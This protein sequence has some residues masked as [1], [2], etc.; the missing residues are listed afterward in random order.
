VSAA[1]RPRV[2]CVDD[3]PNVVEG[4][5]LHLRKRYQ[6]ETAHSASEG[7][8]VIARVPDCAV[9][10]SDMRMPG[11]DGAKFLHQVRRQSPD[12][13][14]MLLTGQADV[15]AAIAAV[16]DGQIF[17]FLSKPCL[18]ATLLGAV[19]AAVAQHELVVAERVLL[20]K[21][22][23]GAVETLCDVLALTSPAAFGRAG[24]IKRLVVAL[25]DQLAL[26]ER[27]QLEV[28]AMLSQLGC[29]SLPDDTLAKVHDGRPLSSDEK[30][31]VARVPAFTEQLLAHIPRLDEVRAILAAYRRPCSGEAGDD[32]ARVVQRGAAVLRVADDFDERISRGSSVQVAVDTLRG[33]IGVYDP[34]VLA[35]LAAIVG[36]DVSVDIREV[37]VAGLQSGMVLAEDVRSTGG[38]L[39][40]PRGA[41][42]TA[43]VIQRMRNYRGGA[44]REP[45]RV[46]V[47]TSIAPLL[48][49]AQLLG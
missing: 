30:E 33:R 42:I 15:N 9:V 1:P 4:L 18:P 47:K 13:V 2:L 39:L 25:A 45:L 23:R 35:A 7:L 17:R 48:R 21:T 28:A 16:N 32:R 41:E 12:V 5:A 37:T 40:L 38:T 44:I 43:S 49:F 22:L 3:E 29:V 36:G 24:R 19:E 8:A 27:W 6:V 10:I 20:E 14:R 34:E 11:V 26:R 46:A 31:M